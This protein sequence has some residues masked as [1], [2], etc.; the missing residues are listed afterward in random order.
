MRN[1]RFIIVLIF[2]LIFIDFNLSYVFAQGKEWQRLRAG[3][4]PAEETYISGEIPSVE[5]FIVA[6]DKIEVFVPQNPELT[7]DVIVG[8]DGYISH[9]LV[10]RMQAAGLTI[11]QLEEKIR[12]EL[13]KYIKD[14]RVSIM[15]KEFSGRISLTLKEIT[16]D[17]IIILGE[18]AYPGI[19]TYTGAIDLIEAIA[20]AG[21][22]T[23]KARKDS[24]MIVR[25]NLTENPEVMRINISRILAKGTSETDIVLMPNDV[26]YV[27]MS[28]IANFNKF[29]SNINPTIQEANDIIE[30][31]RQIRLWPGQ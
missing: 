6:G 27:P 10:G 9:P 7:K 23:E 30:L 15:M 19:Y 17:K 24:I 3:T 26:I 22:F 16:G 4:L 21:D 28:F 13:S 14:P 18:I 29:L 25:G 5:Y 31:R 1:I 20:L 2:C 8:P 11:S 12:Q